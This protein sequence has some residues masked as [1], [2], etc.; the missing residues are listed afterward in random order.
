MAKAASP[1]N[2]F[3]DDQ[4]GVFLGA[5]E[6]PACTQTVRQETWS[7]AYGERQP[8][9]VLRLE[10]HQKLPA[11][12]ATLLLP[13]AHATDV[14]KFPRLHQLEASQVAGYR[15]TWKSEE[16]N[17]FFSRHSGP[18]SLG[19]WASDAEFLY[20][21]HDRSTGHRLL[22]F[23]NGTYA[24]VGGHRLLSSTRPV[25]YAEVAVGRGATRISSSD[26]DAL[27][28]AQGISDFEL[29]VQTASEPRG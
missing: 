13:T 29:K 20:W 17:L 16:H 12:F 10:T 22:I 4:G 21:S 11:E 8:R 15:L 24:D 1:D 23:C 18:W 6:K 5:A 9:L 2:W 25:R 26:P 14:R 28:V 27:K 7:P 3:A 19:Q